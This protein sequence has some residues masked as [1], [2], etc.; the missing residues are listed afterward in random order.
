MAIKGPSDP[1][2]E[3]SK[4]FW[5]TVLSDARRNGWS[6]DPEGHGFGFLTCP[7]GDCSIRVPSTPKSNEKI[8]A[9]AA[10]DVRACRH[11]DPQ[12]RSAMDQI[13]DSLDRADALM[14]AAEGL[15]D[16][17]ERLADAEELLTEAAD[18]V[19]DAAHGAEFDDAVTASEGA[20]AGATKRLAEAGYSGEAQPGPVLGDAA[21]LVSGASRDAE[22]LPKTAG[23]GKKDLRRRIGQAQTRLTVLRL[24][25]P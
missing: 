4:A 12:S 17:A 8:A 24:R 10:T 19:S 23:P 21:T 2:P 1:W 16:S 13:Q 11:A 9:G 20:A 6:L 25:L 5:R 3:H 22:R 15:L 18:A 14:D 7:S